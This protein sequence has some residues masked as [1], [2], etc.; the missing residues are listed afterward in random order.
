MS[1]EKFVRPTHYSELP[2]IAQLYTET[3]WN[4]GLVGTLVHPHREKYPQ[5]MPL[6][7][8]REARVTFQDPR[9]HWIV[10]IQPDSSGGPDKIAGAALWECFGEGGK[11]LKYWWFDPRKR[12]HLSFI[13]GHANSDT[14]PAVKASVRHRHGSPRLD[15][16]ISRS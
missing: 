8:L 14:R 7:W 11:A 6:F 4:D 10:A 9:I 1:N 2:L 16:A 3:F 12:A 13:P 15:L 5:D